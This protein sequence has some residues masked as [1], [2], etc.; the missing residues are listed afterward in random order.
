MIQI[1]MQ[2]P[3]R[4][5]VCF[6]THTD[7]NGVE[8]WCG[9]DETARDLYTA[10]INTKRPEWCPLKEQDNCENCAMAIED[11]QPVVRCKDCKY[12]DIETLEHCWCL[13]LARSREPDWF[14]ADGVRKE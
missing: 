14:C 1:D 7:E 2:M 5:G 11:R 12:C 13:I 10:D 6:A 8:S 9:I 4:C 3:E